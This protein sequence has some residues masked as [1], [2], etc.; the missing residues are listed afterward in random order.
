MSLFKFCKRYECDVSGR[1]VISPKYRGLLKKLRRVKVAKHITF[2]KILRLDTKIESRKSAKR[3]LHGIAFRNRQLIKKFYEISYSSYNR[4]L[5][6]IV[7]SR[8]NSDL[9]RFYKNMESRLDICLWRGNFFLTI[10]EARKHILAGHVFV[11]NSKIR[12]PSYILS[13]GDVVSLE[14]SAVYNCFLN[15]LFKLKQSNF[16][17]ISSNLE[18]NYKNFSFVYSYDVFSRP[19]IFTNI[20]LNKI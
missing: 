1:L 19:Y 11:N 2:D 5:R 3:S 16:F 10:A 18:V 14:R 13:P 4:L 15:V 6:K 7:N 20:S 9:N 12:V 8:G 17:N